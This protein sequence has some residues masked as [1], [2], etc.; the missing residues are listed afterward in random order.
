MGREEGGD[1]VPVIDKVDRGNAAG[2]DRSDGAI[3]K[4]NGTE[5]RELKESNVI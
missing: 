1:K 5:G 3:L 4:F 2:T